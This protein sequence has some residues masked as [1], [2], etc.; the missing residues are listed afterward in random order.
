MPN[1]L[2]RASRSHSFG[3]S[4]M[5]MVRSPWTLECP[6]TGQAPAPGLPKLPCSSRTLTISLMVSTECGCCVTPRA[7]QKMVALDRMSIPAT[8]SICSGPGPV[9][10]SVSAQSSS[11][12]GLTV[13]LKAVGL[14]LDKGTVDDGARV[15]FLL[16]QQQVAQ[17]LEQ[18]QVPAH[19]DLQV[20][21]G[22][23]RA[24]AHHA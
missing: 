3:F 22:Q 17:R 11:R 4:Q 15:L 13:C 8:S 5:P 6:R 21:V 18:R 12:A 9:A 2:S 7:Q 1:S 16:R 24:A 20:L 10:F 14:S 19:L 23:R